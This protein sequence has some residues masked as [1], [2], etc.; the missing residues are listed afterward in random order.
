MIDHL[1]DYSEALTNDDICAEMF[2]IIYPHASNA[3]FSNN[4][5][6]TNGHKKS[7]EINGAFG[8]LNK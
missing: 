5:Y 3:A 1:L 7:C 4:F 8:S 6:I 2:D